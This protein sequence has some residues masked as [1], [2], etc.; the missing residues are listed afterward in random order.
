MSRPGNG[1]FSRNNKE[2]FSRH[3]I[4]LVP[5]PQHCGKGRYHEEHKTHFTSLDRRQEHS[6]MFD[7]RVVGGDVSRLG[8][9]PWLVSIQLVENVT[10]THG[11]GGSLIAPQWVVTAAHCFELVLH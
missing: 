5:V 4:S 7:K 2:R 10:S 3:R 6:V 9:W 11:C 1:R 8:E